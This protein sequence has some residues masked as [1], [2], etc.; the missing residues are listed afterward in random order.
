MDGT[1]DGT[2]KLKVTSTAASSTDPGVVVV[3]S[4]NGQNTNGI[5]APATS[6]PVVQAGMQYKAVAA[7]QTAS[8]FGATGSTGDYIS[9][10][11]VIPATTSPGAISLLD[12]TTAVTIFTG[13]ASSITNLVPF[14]IPLGM[15]STLGAWK[16]TTSTNE[17]IIGVG[18]FT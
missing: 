9:H 2:Q 13:G 1:I 17:S 18:N 8:V 11:V 14:A 4:P 3:I 15:F 16:V 12:S 6:A 7:S 10:I 5:K